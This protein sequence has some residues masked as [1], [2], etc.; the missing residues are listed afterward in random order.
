MEMAA[1][2]QA[3]SIMEALVT[4]S[5]MPVAKLISSRLMAPENFLT[6]NQIFLSNKY[7]FKYQTVPLK[8][9]EKE[10]YPWNLKYK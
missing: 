9:G 8:Y 1:Y 3:S 2:C 4:K 7:F 5:F 6:V 10:L